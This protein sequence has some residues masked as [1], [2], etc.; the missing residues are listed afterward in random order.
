MVAGQGPYLVRQEG[1]APIGEKRVEEKRKSWAEIFEAESQSKDGAVQFVQAEIPVAE[2]QNK[3]PYATVVEGNRDSGLGWNLKYVKP[4]AEDRKVRISKSEFDAG[5]TLWNQTV[6]GYVVG[7]RP[8]FMEMKKFVQ[9]QWRLELPKFNML[10]NGVCLFTFKSEED[11]LRIMQRGWTFFGFPL[12][13]K[14]WKPDMNLEHLNIK[15]LHVWIR[16]PKL[17]FSLWNQPTLEKIVS[18]IGQPLATDKPTANR[19][20]L[21]FSRVLVEV[22]LNDELPTCIPIELEEGT[23]Y[24]DVE[25]EWK[26]LLCKRCSKYGHVS[27]V[28]NLPPIQGWVAKPGS[29]AVVEEPVKEQLNQDVRSKEPIVRAPNTVVTEVAEVHPVQTNT[30]K[31]SN[32]PEGSRQ[33]VKN[34]KAPPKNSHGNVKTPKDIPKDKGNIFATKNGKSVITLKSPGVLVVQMVDADGQNASNAK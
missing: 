1:K 6:V 26:P 13:L 33:N 14:Q 3:V 19:D 5:S 32:V 34:Q 4:E 20:R 23:K 17:H 29:I 30:K 10:G 11:K 7:R 8:G 25:F 21:D 24:Q 27:A 9:L 28:C 18:Y 15:K 22:E 16:L 2:E 31:P 12:V